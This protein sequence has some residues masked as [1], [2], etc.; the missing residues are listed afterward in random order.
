MALGPQSPASSTTSVTLGGG[1]G[2]GTGLAVGAAGEFTHLT[3]NTSLVRAM[4]SPRTVNNE[5]AFMHL[6]C[7]CMYSC[8]DGWM[9]CIYV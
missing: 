9:A 4:L 2:L 7:V 6:L 5:P 3:L 1:S 8:K